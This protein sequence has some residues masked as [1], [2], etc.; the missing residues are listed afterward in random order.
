MSSISASHT[1]SYF[2]TLYSCINHEVKYA[3][4]M[5]IKGAPVILGED[6]QRGSVVSAPGAQHLHID[7][8]RPVQ[9]ALPAALLRLH[10]AQGVSDSSALPGGLS[11]HQSDGSLQ[12][13]LFTHS[14]RSACGETRQHNLLNAQRLRGAAH[15]RDFCSITSNISA[16]GLLVCREPQFWRTH[17]C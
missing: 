5:R 12:H 15:H 14:Q 16:D 7:G 6:I 11:L 10:M 4:Q 1:F 13:R 3:S 17:V 2:S 8:G 9:L